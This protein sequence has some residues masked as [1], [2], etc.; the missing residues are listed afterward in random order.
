MTDTKGLFHAGKALEEQFLE[1]ELDD[2]LGF[3]TYSNSLLV[4]YTVGQWGGSTGTG[5]LLPC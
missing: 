2:V 5:R 1:G 3:N 4:P